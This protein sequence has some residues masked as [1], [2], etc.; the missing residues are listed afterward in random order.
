MGFSGPGVFFDARTIRSGSYF[1]G[2][3]LMLVVVL[4]VCLLRKPIDSFAVE[5]NQVGDFLS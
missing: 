5:V 3:G 1:P 2:G 4:C